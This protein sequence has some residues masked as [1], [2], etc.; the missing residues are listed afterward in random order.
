MV[1][2]ILMTLFL[3][4]MFKLLINWFKKPEKFPP[5][6]PTVPILG[7][8]P[9]LPG[10]GIEKFV[11]EYIASF[12]KV[13]G[14]VA[15]SNY[16][17][18]INDWKLAKSLFAKEEFSGR[19]R[20]YTTLW[21]R[22]VGGRNLG[23]VFTDGQFYWNQKHFAVKHLKNFGFGK[24]SLQTVIVDQANDLTNFL[25]KQ[26]V[27]GNVEIS[28]EVF[29]TPVINV[30][31]SMM[32]GS[33]FNRND[34]KAQQMLNDLAYIFSS[35]IL[36]TTLMFP[37]VR[38][39]FPSL[40]GYKRRLELLARLRDYF[41]QEIE[42]HEKELVEESPRDFM[43]V[44]ITE[45][46]RSNNPEFDKMQ[47]IMICLD[48]FGAGS[49]TSSST[50]SWAVLFLTLHEE[51]QEKCAHEILERV[52]INEELRLEMT[53]DLHYCQAFI[54]ETQRHAQVA[55]SSLMHK[56]TEKTNLP[57]GHQLPAKC[58]VQSNLKKFMMDPQLW[59]NPDNFDPDRFL[60]EERK[61]TKPEYFVP[62]G[63]GKRMCLGEPLAK[64]EIFIFFVSLVRK[65]KFQPTEG[66]SLDPKNYS[67]GFTKSPNKFNVKI[68]AR[69]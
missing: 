47:L 49:D 4:L 53:N 17:V 26:S 50:L 8:L 7:S 67:S 37:W 42:K 46:K 66:S 28:N 35:K 34:A 45:M 69:I 33:T 43:D 3:L 21:A 59:K 57:T 54:A 41:G 65:L 15:G 64:A 40:T 30:L 22:S 2:D 24:T 25:E 20:N 23:L 62:F 58:L 19:L 63:H 29:A 13:T 12:G 55:V 44:Y 6:P 9:F 32:A 61:F 36:V 5:G 60:N 10:S 39:I 48:M 56:V 27:V 52:P 14:L 16:I 51:M 1:S 38:Y 18:M 11:S 68:S 31:W